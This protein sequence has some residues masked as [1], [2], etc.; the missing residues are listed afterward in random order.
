MNFVSAKFVKK[1]RF[2]GVRRFAP[3]EKA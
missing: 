3:P 2:S 1:T